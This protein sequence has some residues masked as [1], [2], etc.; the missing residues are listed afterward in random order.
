MHPVTGGWEL[1]LSVPV[2]AVH[3][4]TKRYGDMTAVHALSFELP[5]GRVLAMVGPNGAGKTTSLR[6]IAGI[7][8]PTEGRAAVMGIDVQRAPVEAKQRMAWVP[9]DP[10]L[11]DALTVLEHL[12][13]VATTWGLPAYR[14]RAEALLER[15]DLADKRDA[16]AQTLSTGM[17]QKLALCAASLHQPDLL[18]LDEPMTGL[19]PTAIRTLKAWVAE[20]AA[21][22]A[23]L[24]ISSH[25][26]T[27]VADMC[28]DLLIV[29]KG[30][31]TFFGTIPEARATY[32]HDDLESLFFEAT[33]T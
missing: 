32:G 13:F 30:A 31:A 12:E 25:L 9:H 5:P 1:L 22:G 7:I 18:M 10:K 33:G 28:T 6:A 23:S 29:V 15:F 11:F 20:E 27:V 16:I 19:D 14:D 17:R 8:R 4:L 21:R 3:D 26:L 24:I 2:V